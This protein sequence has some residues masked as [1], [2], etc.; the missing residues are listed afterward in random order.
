MVGVAVGVE[1]AVT[2]GSSVGV[3]V[4]DEV[5]VGDGLELAP[6]TMYTSVGMG[7]GLRGALRWHA[8]STHKP[9][10]RASHR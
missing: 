7:V 4:L 5:A 9:R 2:V 3:F 10:R 6:W 1:V 8:A